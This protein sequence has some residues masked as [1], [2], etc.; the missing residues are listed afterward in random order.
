VDRP[1]TVAH[2]SNNSITRETEEI[3]LH[4]FRGIL[5]FTRPS[6]K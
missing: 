4:E 3:G 5:G 6:F 2:P 1:D